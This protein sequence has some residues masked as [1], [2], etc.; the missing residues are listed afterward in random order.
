MDCYTADGWGTIAQPPFLVPSAPQCMIL[1]V[2][3]LTAGGCVIRRLP[4][5]ERA[6]GNEAADFTRV[7]PYVGGHV[8]E[9][10]VIGGKQSIVDTSARSLANPAR[11]SA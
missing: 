9:L 7:T 11:W 10:F 2:T 5:V 6:L 3:R 1:T 8:C 4:F